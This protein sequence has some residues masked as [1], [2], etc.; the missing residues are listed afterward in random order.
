M[1]VLGP[2]EADALG[3]VL[4]H[5][6]LFA[7]VPGA[8]LDPRD[9]WSRDDCVD[10]LIGRMRS[11]MDHGVR[12]IVD[13][14]PIDLGR[15]PEMMAEVA[16]RS[17][18][19]IVCST[20]FY[21]EH[22]GIEAYWRARSPEEIADFFLHE[23]RSGIASTGIRPGV[24]KIASFDPPGQWDRLVMAGAAIAAAES[25]LAVVTHCENSAGGDVQ[26]SVLASKGVD[27][28]RCLI[29]HQDQ[30]TEVGAIEALAD[31]GS[32][33][34]IDR[35]GW[36]V[37]APDDQ[38]ADTIAALLR[39]GYGDKLCISQ[40]RVCCWRYA[41]WPWVMPEGTD[42]DAVRPAIEQELRLPHTYLFTD[43]MPLLSARGVNES[44]IDPLLE[45]NARRLL[46]GV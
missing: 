42:L 38:R 43:F 12:T 11:L 5:E 3:R 39:D 18:M 45:E 14:C 36:Q 16:R 6:H 20:G 30:E 9:S 17:E 37:L 2:L 28:S 15:D 33:V 13:P 7:T 41:Q 46:V 31:R 10:E 29:G 23:I 34:G 40:D 26:Q 27:L 8:E 44:Q 21:H 35:I 1:G 25:G 4:V 32:F 22:T 24:I 19:N